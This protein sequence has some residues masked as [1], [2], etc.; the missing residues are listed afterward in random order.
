VASAPGRPGPGRIADSV[1]RHPWV[2]AAGLAATFA[3]M[4]GGG[5][6][7]AFSGGSA[8]PAQDCGLVPC[9]AAL[10]ASVRTSAAGPGSEPVPGRTPATATPTVTRHAPAPPSSPLPSS[11]APAPEGAAP[12]RAGPAPEPVSFAAPAASS[13]GRAVSADHA[14]GVGYGITQDGQQDIHGQIVI[15]NNGPVPLTGWRIRVVLPGDTDYQVLDAANRSAGDALVMAAPLAGQAIAAGST[16]VIV[17][18]A[19]GTT[20]TPARSTF[21]DSGR[22]RP[23]AAQGSAAGQDA[24][25]GPGPA[26]SGPGRAEGWPGGWLGGWLPSG[27]PNGSRPGRGGAGHGWPGSGR[28][29]H[30]HGW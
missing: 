24:A 12:H 10:P 7:L 6:A 21:T 14:V 20:S 2:T 5:L 15:V 23:R 3:A 26:G 18:T 1:A 8:R 30:H 22:P 29:G 28:P 11:A 19:R 13:A 25:A 27:W 4:A 17:F 16:E 9:T